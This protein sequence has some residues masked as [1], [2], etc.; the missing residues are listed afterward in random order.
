MKPQ[1]IAT[2]FILAVSTAW[3]GPYEDATSAYKLKDRN[4]SINLLQPQELI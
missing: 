2:T 3:A 4:V 1:H